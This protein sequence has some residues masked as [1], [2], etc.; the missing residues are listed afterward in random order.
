[1]A[2]NKSKTATSIN[3]AG[4]MEMGKNKFEVYFRLEKIIFLNRGFVKNI[5]E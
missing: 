4:K 2:V 1:M 3:D 5:Q